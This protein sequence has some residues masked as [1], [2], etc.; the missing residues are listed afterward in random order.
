[1]RFAL[2][3]TTLLCLGLVSVALFSGCKALHVLVGSGKTVS[4]DFNFTD[5]SKISAGWNFSVEISKGPSYGIKV[6]VDDNLQSYLDVSRDGDT[7]KF[8]MNDGYTLR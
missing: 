1:M 4:Q 7:L 8:D 2:I 5:F 3:F 6:T